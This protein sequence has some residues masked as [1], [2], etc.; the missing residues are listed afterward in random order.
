[1]QPAPPSVEKSADAIPLTVGSCR[2]CD[3]AGDAGSEPVWNIGISRLS[4]KRAWTV[5]PP[6]LPPMYGITVM[7]LG[8]GSPNPL[9]WAT[10]VDAAYGMARG[11]SREVATTFGE[12]YVAKMTLLF[13][14]S[15]TWAESVVQAQMRPWPAAPCCAAAIPGFTAKF[16]TVAP[17]GSYLWAIN[18]A[19]PR[20][21]EDLRE[22]LR[23][24]TP[25]RQYTV[26]AAATKENDLER[27]FVRAATILLYGMEPE[28]PYTLTYWP[29]GSYPGPKDDE[30]SFVSA[31][32]GPLS[33]W[34]TFVLTT[35]AN[36]LYVPW[37]GHGGMRQRL[38]DQ[39]THFLWLTLSP[40][41]SGGCGSG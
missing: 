31:P 28:R 37:Y 34:G 21:A 5:V 33:E 39:A 12:E 38:S 15:Q 30:P 17:R 29:G 25:D 41:S 13:A 1:M 8:D 26:T 10:Y 35:P 19:L 11:A 4:T 7:S 14:W 18:M 20:M 40:S 27:T 16:G 36:P 3:A 9:I 24:K 2:H 6:K 32:T 22:R 23:V